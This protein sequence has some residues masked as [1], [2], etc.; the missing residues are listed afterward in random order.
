MN[1]TQPSR[2]LVPEGMTLHG[3]L[4]EGDSASMVTTAFVALDGSQR[5]VGAETGLSEI[6]AKV[7]A[8]Q[9]RH[10]TPSRLPKV[11]RRSSGPL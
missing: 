9:F 4:V 10:R 6:R 11:P 1:Q 2:V 5:E 3:A 8:P 7:R